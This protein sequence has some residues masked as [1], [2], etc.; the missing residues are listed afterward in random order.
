MCGE[1]LVVK[2]CVVLLCLQCWVCGVQ[3]DQVGIGIDLQVSGY[4]QGLCVIVQGVFKQEVI[5][6]V[7][8]IWGQYIVF[9][10]GQVLVVFKQVQFFGCIDQYI[11]IGIDVE[12]IVF[13]CECLYWEQVVVQVGFG[14]WVQ[15]GYGLVGGD[16]CV[17]VIGDVGGM[18]QVLVCIYWCVVVQLLYWVLVVLGQVGF[19]FVY[20]FGDM[21]VYWVIGEWQ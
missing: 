20:L 14:D 2:L 12:V 15:I 8:G 3:F 11:G 21:D 10:Q 6:V 19:D 18:Y 13:V 16:G 17:F 7:G 1:Y 9:V 5:G 4:V